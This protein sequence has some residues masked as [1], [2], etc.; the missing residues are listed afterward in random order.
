MLSCCP[1]PQVCV[2]HADS[3]C[4]RAH[5]GGQ[6]SGHTGVR[7]SAA[8]PAGTSVVHEAVPRSVP[9]RDPLSG[10]YC[11]DVKLQKGAQYKLSYYYGRLVTQK[12][13]GGGTHG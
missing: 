4:P 7:A 12:S 9:C 10:T 8:A 11:Q 5:S 1:M 13:P 3:C 2:C 6:A